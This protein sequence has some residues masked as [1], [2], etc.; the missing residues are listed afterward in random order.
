VLLRFGKL[1]GQSL[2]GLL[3]LPLDRFDFRAGDIACLDFGGLGGGLLELGHAEFDDVIDL[4][5]DEV[6]HL[7]FNLGHASAERA[8]HQLRQEHPDA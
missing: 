3:R 6:L 2:G 5:F 1:L 8:P 4:F 7:L